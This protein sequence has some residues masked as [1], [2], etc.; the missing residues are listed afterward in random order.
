MANDKLNSIIS[1]LNSGD[2]ENGKKQLEQLLKTDPQ[3]PEGYFWFRQIEGWVPADRMNPDNGLQEKVLIIWRK[4]TG[5][6]EKDNL[7]LDCY[8]LKNRIN[9][10]EKSSCDFDIIYINGSN[11]VPSLQKEEDTWKVRL[12][13]E[14]FTQRMWEIEG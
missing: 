12:I 2:F 4:L 9:P 11:N 1:L 6:L 8:L 5:D 13:E 3:N 10:L 7:V 14:E